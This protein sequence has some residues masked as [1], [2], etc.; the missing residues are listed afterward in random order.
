MLNLGRYQTLINFLSPL[1]NDNRT[2][3]NTNNKYDKIIP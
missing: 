2:N 3:T 1:Q